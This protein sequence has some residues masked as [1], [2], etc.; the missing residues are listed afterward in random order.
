M[1]IL[2]LIAVGVWLIHANRDWGYPEWLINYQGGFIR[3]GLEGE[4]F[5]RLSLLTHVG[6]LYFVGAV[7]I[8]CYLIIFAVVWRL[9]VTSR[10]KWWT[11]ALVISPST[12][13]FPVISRTS[14][15]KDILF[16]AALALL[17]DWLRR[18]ANEPTKD[19]WLACVLSLVMPA[20]ILCQEPVYVYLPYFAAALL[21]C[22]QSIRR[23]ATV[24]ALPA[25]LA[26]VAFVAVATHSGTYGQMQ[27]ICASVGHPVVEDC[28]AGIQIVGLP[29]QDVRVFIRDYGYW[30]HYPLCVLLSLI[31]MVGAWQ[32]FS[33][34]NETRR[35]ALVVV[36][37]ACLAGLGSIAVFR[38]G[39]DWG[40]WINLHMLSL[41]L[42]IL[43]IE[44]YRNKEGG[45]LQMQKRSPALSAAV[46]LLLVVYATCWS[47]PGVK[48]KPLFGYLSLAHRLLHWTGSLT[49]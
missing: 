25:I 33:R 49:A 24:F 42:L 9:L 10:W 31:P 40:R 5:R 4:I 37:A 12:L 36:T 47:M 1:L 15:R 8:S 17:V 43:L 35:L 23:A 48:D 28:P 44:T 19:K 26:S 2:E 45:G 20:L 16:F 34:E 18:H 11:I 3:R 39:L 27:H 13:A 14:F 32:A 38:W 30:K 7:A 46:A 21:V 41:T 29:A 6:S 22:L